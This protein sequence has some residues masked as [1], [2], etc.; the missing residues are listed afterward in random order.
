M[1]LHYL[2][3]VQNTLEI[4]EKSDAA[5]GLGRFVFQLGSVEKLSRNIAMNVLRYQTRH[6]SR[7]IGVG[8]L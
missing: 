1:H 4:L 6:A 7:I 3:R 5:S 8:K 2:S